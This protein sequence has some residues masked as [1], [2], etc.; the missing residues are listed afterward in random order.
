MAFIGYSPATF[1][2][3]HSLHVYTWP[4]AYIPGGPAVIG[5]EFSGG[6]GHFDMEAG[7]LDTSEGFEAHIRSLSG[8]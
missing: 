8:T 1:H 7:R 5:L 3:C 4:H 6:V 2:T